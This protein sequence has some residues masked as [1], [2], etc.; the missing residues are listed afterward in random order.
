MT[1]LSTEFGVGQPPLSPSPSAQPGDRLDKGYDYVALGHSCGATLWMQLVSSIGA[2]LPPTVRR[3]VAAGLAAGIY[4]L[5]A[6]LHAHAEVPAYGEIVR[7][8]F[9]GE[10]WAR[11]EASPVCVGEYGPEGWPEGWLCVLGHS[12]EDE[13]LEVGQ[14]MAMAGKLGLDGWV[15]EDWKAYGGK[16]PEEVEKPKGGEGVSEEERDVDE[17]ERKV[18]LWR[19]KGGHDD[20]WRDGVQLTGMMKFLVERIFDG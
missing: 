19:M 1:F 12:G 11:R 9:G 16:G 7:G 18:V 10:E 15:A 14:V 3:P 8:A 17:S 5:P 6:F 4:D 2:S 13:L 20:L